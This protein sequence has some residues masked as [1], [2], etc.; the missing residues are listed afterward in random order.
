[1]KSFFFNFE[2]QRTGAQKSFPVSSSW[3]CR[4]NEKPKFHRSASRITGG[5]GK[6][7]KDLNYWGW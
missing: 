6:L 3:K 2:N 5:A 1:M 7:S 4:T